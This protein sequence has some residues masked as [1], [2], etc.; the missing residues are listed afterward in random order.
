MD[1]TTQ[2]LVLVVEDDPMIAQLL[3]L[4]FRSQGYHGVIAPDG[5]SAAAQ[6]QTMQPDLITLDLNLPG[7][8]GAQLL[9]DL[10]ATPAT[11]ALP[12]IIISACSD[13]EPAIS[14]RAQAV[15]CKPFGIEELMAV[16]RAVH[17]DAPLSARAVGE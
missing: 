15:L 4:M 9:A 17:A 8:S 11:A 14:D 3:V 1:A 2:P 5:A 7:M 13:I 10:R 16:V 6:L 12:V